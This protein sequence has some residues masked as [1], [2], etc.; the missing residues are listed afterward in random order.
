MFHHR[1]VEY[2]TDG[3]AERI[4]ISTGGRQL[5]SVDAKTGEP[6]P[7]FGDGGWVDLLQDLG[8]E[9][10]A[11]NIGD[12][13]PPIV[14][15][16]TVIVGSIIMDFPTMK[17]APPGHVRGYDVRTGKLKWRF[18]SI[19]QAGEFGNETWGTTPGRIAATRTSGR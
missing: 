9:V 5:V 16:D 18:H 6:D 12:N 19:P 3:E 15:G 17:S 1:G 4:L 8:R 14:V 2:W 13:K 7:E 10:D 11:R